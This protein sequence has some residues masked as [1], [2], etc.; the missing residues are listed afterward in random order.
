MTDIM[1][2]KHQY[3]RP[4]SWETFERLFDPI[5]LDDDTL[6][7]QIGEVPKDADPH[8][9]WTILDP[10]TDKLYLAAGFHFVNR[11]GYVKCKN[12]WGGDPNDH[13]DYIYC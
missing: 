5:P 10:S 1:P 11:F 3:K 2:P 9:W 6:L 7:W 13:P 8:H 4:R 12:R